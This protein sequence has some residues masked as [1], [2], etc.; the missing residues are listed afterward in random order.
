MES[1]RRRA[2][3]IS[4][5]EEETGDAHIMD[6]EGTCRDVFKLTT[7][8]RRHT[9]IIDYTDSIQLICHFSSS[10]TRKLYQRSATTSRALEQPVPCR[11]AGVP[12]AIRRIVR[13][14]DSFLSVHIDML[15]LTSGY[16]MIC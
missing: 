7:K 15:R 5:E 4:E 11:F 9:L 14:Y 2:P 13:T 3:F 1:L 12:S 8:G 6:E 10:R 16:A